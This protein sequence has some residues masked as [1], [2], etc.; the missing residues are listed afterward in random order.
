M[1]V[2]LIQAYYQIPI[3]NI[4]AAFGVLWNIEYGAEFDIIG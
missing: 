3:L 4:Y 1:P 2:A